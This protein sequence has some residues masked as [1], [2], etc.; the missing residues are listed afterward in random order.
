[1]KTSVYDSAK[2]LTRQLRKRQT[3]A[4]KL[5]W[6][7]L[8]N[9]KFH[10]QKFFRQH[11]IF[12]EYCRQKVFFIAD[13]YCRESHLVIE[14]D[15][16]IHE[17]QQDYDEYRTEIINSLGIRV[18]RFKNEEIEQKMNEVLTKIAHLMNV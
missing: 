9:R 6:D 8:R 4:E 5:L 14:I 10:G 13:F 16:K 2:E 11:P 17:Y 7:E 18:A 1:L 12:F 15:G 3:S